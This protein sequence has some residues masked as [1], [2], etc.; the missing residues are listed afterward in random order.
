MLA[1]SDLRTISLHQ[2]LY[3]QQYSVILIRVLLN[4]IEQ[5]KV[6]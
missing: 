2:Y 4:I 5:N 6:E 3:S 1:Q